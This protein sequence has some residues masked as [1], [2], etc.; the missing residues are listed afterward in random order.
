MG[1]ANRRRVDFILQVLTATSQGSSR[2]LSP[3]VSCTV[4][5]MDEEVLLGFQTA[6]PPLDHS[7]ATAQA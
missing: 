7:D 2:K 5:S 1:A 4:Q 6:E 3:P